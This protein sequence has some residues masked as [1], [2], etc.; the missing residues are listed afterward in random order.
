MCSINSPVSV[1]DADTSR[2][3]IVDQRL[4][5]PLVSSLSIGVRVYQPLNLLLFIE[6]HSQLNWLRRTSRN[7]VIMRG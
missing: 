7:V 4:L 5:V 3:S 6:H 1:L 2:E